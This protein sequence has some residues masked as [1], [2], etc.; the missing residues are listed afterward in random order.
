MWRADLDVE[1]EQAPQVW[2]GPRGLQAMSLGLYRKCQGKPLKCVIRGSDVIRFTLH[3]DGPA[4][5]VYILHHFK[6]VTMYLPYNYF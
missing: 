3:K 4:S 1:G 2:V 6:L 5:S